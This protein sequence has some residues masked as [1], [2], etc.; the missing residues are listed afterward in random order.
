MKSATFSLS[1][2]GGEKPQVAFVE[3][4]LQPRGLGNW[5]GFHAAPPRSTR[6]IMPRM[7]RR[8]ARLLNRNCLIAGAG[9]II[10]SSFTAIL[11]PADELPASSS[12]L[13]VV[14]RPS[15]AV[16]LCVRCCQPLVENP[17]RGLTRVQIPS[18][19]KFLQ[20]FP[21]F[22]R[23]A[24]QDRC[25]SHRSSETFV[26]NVRV[27]VASFLSD[28]AIKRECTIFDSPC[29]SS[30]PALTD[31]YRKAKKSRVI[32]IATDQGAASPAASSLR[33]VVQWGSP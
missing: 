8:F 24:N 27:H 20:S 11:V 3:E 28:L 2:M 9:C 21:L 23:Q 30:I 6:R 15:R 33:R 5:Q 25:I 32:A 22:L 31:C 18:Q 14:A 10:P 1:R 12:R 29:Q 17:P 16:G 19:C 4:G 7:P 26:S 13:P